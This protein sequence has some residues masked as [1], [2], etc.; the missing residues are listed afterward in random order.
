RSLNGPTNMKW[1]Q[2]T[3]APIWY[4]QETSREHSVFSERRHLM[5]RLL[6][7]MLVLLTL[8]ALASQVVA[9]QKENSSP[10][11]NPLLRLLQSKG[12]ITEQEAAAVAEAASPSESQA[13]LAKLLLSKGVINQEE[14][15]QTLASIA[16]EAASANTPR[17]VNAAAHVADATGAGG[18]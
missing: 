9:Q 10:A 15:D 5:K 1:G 3:L 6:Q 7:L 8:V 4:W 18:P 12:I 16:A 2:A 13:K 14:Y 17:V 11:P